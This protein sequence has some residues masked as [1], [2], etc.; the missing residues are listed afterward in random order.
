MG[1]AAAPASEGWSVDVGLGQQTA[2]D[3]VAVLP[4]SKALSRYI[5]VCVCQSSMRWLSVKSQCRVT[6]V[7]EKHSK[8]AGFATTSLG[9][10]HT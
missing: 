9:V 3:C 5:C 4:Y 6:G 10:L 2:L 1:H 8:R 7:A